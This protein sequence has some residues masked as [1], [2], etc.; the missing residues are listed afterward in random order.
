M[1]IESQTCIIL[2]GTMFLAASLMITA[3]VLVAFLFRNRTED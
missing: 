2:Y 3:K 1:G